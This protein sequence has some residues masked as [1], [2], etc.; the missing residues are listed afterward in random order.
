MTFY[1]AF[2]YDPVPYFSTA[3][4]FLRSTVRPK[5]TIAVPFA[6]RPS[7]AAIAIVTAI[8]ITSVLDC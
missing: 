3:I 7:V 8:V 4:A 5:P 2:I 6:S 1:I